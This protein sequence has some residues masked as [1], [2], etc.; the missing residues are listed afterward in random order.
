LTLGKVNFG[1]LLLS[2]KNKETAILKNLEDVPISF[3]FDKES[4]KGEPDYNNSL[5]V[6]PMSGVVK[7]ESE[8][9]IEIV[10]QPKNEI[11]YNYNLSCNV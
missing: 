6:S 3:Y 9:P 7:P 11:S 4:I 10:F 8:I 2:G 1:P 5:Q